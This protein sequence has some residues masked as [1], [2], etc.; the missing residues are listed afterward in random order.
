MVKIMEEYKWI[1]RMYYYG[2][3]MSIQIIVEFFLVK[4]VTDLLNRFIQSDRNTNQN[5]VSI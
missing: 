3:Y 2:Y 4:L 5:K 1:C